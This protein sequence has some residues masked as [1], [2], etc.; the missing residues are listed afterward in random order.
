MKLQIQS[1][2]YGE[3]LVTFDSSIP[4]YQGQTWG[5][6]GAKVAQPLIQKKLFFL[7]IFFIFVVDPIFLELI[8]ACFLL[9]DY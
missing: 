5:G 1:S 2:K 8:I 9:V 7:I 4:Y 3:Q 6:G